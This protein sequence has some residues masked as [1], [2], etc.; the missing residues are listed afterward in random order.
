MNQRIK[1]GSALLFLAGLTVSAM[2]E[3][4]P[5]AVLFIYLSVSFITFLAYARDKSAAIKGQWRI[6]ERTLQLLA[7]CCG[8]PG[9]LI[10]QQ[11]LRHKS[12]KVSFRVILGCMIIIN[13]L[14]L[15]GALSD[16]G[17]HLL[18]SIAQ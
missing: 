6:K 3:K 1:V 17:Q 11:Y 7:L 12:Q 2:L 18:Y 5:M 15:F 8:W 4:L 13:N 9:A 14:L 16:R 10:A